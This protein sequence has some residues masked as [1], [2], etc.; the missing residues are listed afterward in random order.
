MNI[1]ECLNENYRINFLEKEIS[2]FILRKEKALSMY[3]KTGIMQ[4][5]TNYMICS[6]IASKHVKQ[7]K[8]LKL[9]K[10]R[11]NYEFY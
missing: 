6:R 4:Y 2:K 7:L 8:E 1:I 9:E 3:K 5:R 10:E 11:K